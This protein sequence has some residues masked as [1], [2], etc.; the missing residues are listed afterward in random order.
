M[1]LVVALVEDDVEDAVFVNVDVLR[2]MLLE[3]EIV[4]LVVGVPVRVV[5]GVE[6]E[7]LEIVVVVVRVRVTVVRVR[8]VD[9]VEDVMVDV[10][11]ERV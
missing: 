4:V 6:D 3:L 8:L 10:T 1:E 11:V 7:V 5:D 2:D 9:G